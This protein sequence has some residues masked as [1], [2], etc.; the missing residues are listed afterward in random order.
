MGKK[1]RKRLAFEV[2]K[3]AVEQFLNKAKTAAELALEF[4]VHVD[5]IYQWKAQVE[6][7]NRNARIDELETEGH[8]PAD[9]KRIMDLEAQVKEY[10]QKLAEQLV[11]NDLLKKLQPTAYPHLRK[12]NGSTEIALLLDQSKKH[13]K[14]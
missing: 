6:N 9:I 12:S 1:L 10:Q 8:H 4:D 3:K 11:I 13:V 7:R 5:Q 2:K 14:R